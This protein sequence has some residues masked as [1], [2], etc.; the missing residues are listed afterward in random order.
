VGVKNGV[1]MVLAAELKVSQG[2]RDARCHRQKH[3]EDEEQ[4]PVQRV[5]LAAPHLRHANAAA[6]G[7]SGQ[8]DNWRVVN[9]QHT[10]RNSYASARSTHTHTHTTPRVTIANDNKFKQGVCRSSNKD[11]SG[12]GDDGAGAGAGLCVVVVVCVCVGG[13][14]GGG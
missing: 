12:G 10:D 8:Q 14:G 9:L 3:D 11:V 1:P 2:N 5:V 13:G 4:D 7:V 6:A